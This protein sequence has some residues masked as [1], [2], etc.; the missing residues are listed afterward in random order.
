[1]KE[2]EKDASKESAKAALKEQA[3]N[4]GRELPPVGNAAKVALL[5]YVAPV[6][7]AKQ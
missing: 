3:V 5:R 2:E 7:S 4:T 1:M 6:A